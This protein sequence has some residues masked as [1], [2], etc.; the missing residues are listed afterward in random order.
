MPHHHLR[1]Q[2]LYSL[3][4]YAYDNDDGGAPQGQPRHAGNAGVDD[5]DQR[6]KSQEQGADERYLGKDLCDEVRRGLAGTD[7]RDGPVVLAEIIGHF[8]GIILDG[9]IEVSEHEDQ[10]EV[11]HDI[12]PARLVKG[13]EEALPEALGGV[14]EN[15][16][17]LRDG[18]DGAGE[19]QGHHA[20]KGSG[21]FQRIQAYLRR[22]GGQRISGVKHIG[23]GS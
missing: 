1:F 6:H 7:A 9:H 19:D 2:L 16:D 12:Q 15:L 22:A 18:Q 20:G 4:S 11:D 8:Q 21:G 10:E 14:H 3:Q 23:I 17:H 13:I 5:G